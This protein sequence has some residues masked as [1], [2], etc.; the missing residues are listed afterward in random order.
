MFNVL[1]KIKKLLKKQNNI[2]EIQEQPIE[3]EVLTV[4]IKDCI[5]IKIKEECT[6]SEYSKNIEKYEILNN[7]H[8]PIKILFTNSNSGFSSYTKIVEQKIFIVELDNLK[9]FITKNKDKVQISQYKTIN[10]NIYETELEYNNHNNTYRIVKS[11][12]DLNYSTGE[13][14]WYPCEGD[15]VKYFSLDKKEANILLKELLENL[16]KIKNI[17]WKLALEKIFIILSEEFIFETESLVSDEIMSLNPY[18]FKIN[19]ETKCQFDIILND[20]KE[21]IGYIEF[22]FNYDVTS[23]YNIGNVFYGIHDEYRNKGYATRALKLLKKY[24]QDAKLDFNKDLYFY[25][26]YH[27]EASKKVI[28][29]NGGEIIEQGNPYENGGNGKAHIL[30][31]KM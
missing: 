31:I 27:N 19:N 30:K 18:P 16:K 22:D 6:L 12:H 1:T 26:N 7:M 25:V 3:K 17:E 23:K 13:V 10:E 24:I 28:L 8:L 15:M 20:T 5:E 29:N 11:I 4:S 9:F 14:K 21:K 2:I